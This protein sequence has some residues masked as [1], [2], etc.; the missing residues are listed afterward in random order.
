MPDFP[1]VDAVTRRI[2]SPAVL[3]ALK[4]Q[5]EEAGLPV[6]EV[7]RSANKVDVSRA[8]TGFYLAYGSGNKMPNASYAYTAPIPCEPGQTQ[9]LLVGSDYQICFYDANGA[10]ISGRLMGSA[11]YSFVTPP[12]CTSYV[13][14]FNLV[15]MNDLMVVDGGVRPTI[16]VAFRSEISLPVRYLPTGYGRVFV[17]HKGAG[18]RFTTIAAACA[19]A[20]DGDTVLVYPGVYQESVDVRSKEVSIIGVNRKDCI[21]KSISNSYDYPPLEAARGRIANMTIYAEKVV[22]TPNPADGRMPYAIHLDYLYS[23]DGTFEVD[24][25]EVVSDWNAA[26]GVGFKSGFKLHL[27]RSDIRSRADTVNGAFFFHDADAVSQMGTAELVV[28]A[29]NFTAPNIVLMPT[30]YGDVRN[31]LNMTWYR[32]MIYSAAAGKTNGAVGV[33]RAVTG[34][35]WRSYNNFFL[36]PDSFGNNHALFNAP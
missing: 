4:E 1:E 29:C 32:T 31:T 16:Y 24:N 26:L 14:S 22:G 5:L 2:V 28:D 20:N 11:E 23:N 36:T 17:V 35:G 25:C 18:S 7:V 21:L 13:I 8:T 30:S 19:A 10:Y 34:T 3:A 15:R 9:S 12:G 27:S 33:G 6:L